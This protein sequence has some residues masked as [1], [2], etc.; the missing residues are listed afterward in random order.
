MFMLP[1]EDNATPRL[2][3]FDRQI[4]REIES[5]A[6]TLMSSSKAHAPELRMIAGDLYWNDKA[7]F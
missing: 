1:L 6:V 3:T 4:Y 5:I 2:I 7:P